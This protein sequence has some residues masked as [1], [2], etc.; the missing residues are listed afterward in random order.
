MNIDHK[1][2]P[3][4]NHQH[5]KNQHSQQTATHCQIQSGLEFLIICIALDSLSQSVSLSSK[6]A[7]DF[8]DLS[9]LIVIDLFP[10]GNKAIEFH[11]GSSHDDEWNCDDHQD[12][13]RDDG[14]HEVGAV[15]VEGG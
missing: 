15:G 14:V 1:K 10:S 9:T 3:S 6:N 5:C 12:Q 11:H 2:C 13:G 8:I 4:D 7:I